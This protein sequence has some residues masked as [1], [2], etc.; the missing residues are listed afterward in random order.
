M[1]HYFTAA[2]SASVLPLL[3][4]LAPAC[5]EQARNETPLADSS[6]DP[7]DPHAMVPGAPSLLNREKLEE[8]VRNNTD[9]VQACFEKNLVGKAKREGR[10]VAKWAIG[11]KGNVGEA[12]ISETTLKDSKTEECIVAAIK[13][14]KFPAPADA[15]AVVS[16]PFELRAVETKAAVPKKK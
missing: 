7:K 10:V 4:L 8:I 11:P 6:F 1:S 13:S 14:W 5:Q 2:G 3:L 9:A 12:E 16:F 15:P